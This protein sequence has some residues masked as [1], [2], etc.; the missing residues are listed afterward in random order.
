MLYT[1]RDMLILLNSHL[2]CFPWKMSNGLKN[3][4]QITTSLESKLTKMEEKHEKVYM[5]FTQQNYI[6]LHGWLKG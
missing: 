2:K 1:T 6:L 5:A 3:S 4:I